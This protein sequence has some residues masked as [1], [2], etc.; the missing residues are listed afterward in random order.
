MQP[1]VL[2]IDQRWQIVVRRPASG[3]I[4]QSV[5][6]QDCVWTG[7]KMVQASVFAK[8]F[9]S[10]H[11][12]ENELRKMIDDMEYRGGSIGIKQFLKKYP[13]YEGNECQIG[14][15]PV[16]SEVLLLKSNERAHVAG[17]GYPINAPGSP[18][19]PTV[20]VLVEKNERTPDGYTNSEVLVATDLVKVLD[21]KQSF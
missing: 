11:E 19:F 7:E 13:N 1:E 4:A 6:T 5:W 2:K 21:L 8:N 18:Y 16:G 12:A 3:K 15:V 20:K 9:A 10:E 17:E 14:D